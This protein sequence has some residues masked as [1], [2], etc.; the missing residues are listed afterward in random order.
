MTCVSCTTM[1]SCVSMVED[2]SQMAASHFVCEFC[3]QER[4]FLLSKHIR[5]NT[6]MP[7]SFFCHL[8]QMSRQ[9]FGRI[10]F[11]KFMAC[12]RNAK[13]SLCLLGCPRLR[14]DVSVFRCCTCLDEMLLWTQVKNCT[15]HRVSQ[16][17][18]W[19]K[20]AK[21]YC[22]C[23]EVTHSWKLSY[24]HTRQSLNENTCVRQFLLFW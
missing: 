20:R 7:M 21:L 10:L 15:K 2:A 8:F 6:A 24:K 23:F 14:C 19:V 16:N 1:M 5:L 12:K 9:L 22:G 18:P 13:G 17:L 3:A 11:R 4:M